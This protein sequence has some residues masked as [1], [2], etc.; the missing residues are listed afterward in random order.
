M[1]ILLSIVAVAAVITLTGCAPDKHITEVKALP[2]SY[3]INEF[4]NPILRVPDPNLT[5]DQ[6][7]DYRKVCD[8][9][10]WKVD[11]TEQHQYFVE[12]RCDY[13][14]VKD[15]AFAERDKADIVSEGDV[16]Q[17][18]FGS[19]GHP[20]LNYAGFV[21]RFKGGSIK[22]FKIDTVRVMEMASNN[23]VTN[24]DE[25]FSYLTNSRIPVKPASPFTDTT[26]GNTL[27]AF[28]PGHNAVEAARLAYLWKRLPLAV[29]DHVDALGYPA[30]NAG[31][32]PAGWL[33][34]NADRVFPVNPADV[35]FVR[36]NVGAD[37]PDYIPNLIKEIP[38]LPSKLFCT[39]A[40]C[41]DSDGKVVGRAPAPIQAQEL[42]KGEWVRVSATGTVGEAVVASR[43]NSAN[44]SSD[45]ATTSTATPAPA[46]QVAQAAQPT[47]AAPVTPQVVNSAVAVLTGASQPQGQPVA[48]TTVHSGD[49][50]PDGWPKM[51]PCIQKLQ[52]KFAVDQ[53]KQNAD[54][55]TSLEQMQEWA[56]V[57][58][59]LGQ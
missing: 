20:A 35:Q 10:K 25:A 44:D 41:Y 15:S 13:K 22:D 28:Y 12:Y 54:T 49:V 6:A 51:T 30:L 34:E 14:G 53:Q 26:Y 18:A 19:D 58:K 50:G 47:P 52:D 21:I 32:Q 48:N 1:K 23:K 3:P 46:P 16:Y 43:P 8:S 11:Q 27:A 24:A 37:M 38:L 29:D 7:L 39:D 56:D 36:R 45:V 2:F 57:C 59:S 31:R 55:S 17:W 40:L 42:A 33:E 4:Q 9:V 5:V